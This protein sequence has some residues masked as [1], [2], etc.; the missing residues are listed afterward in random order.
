MC[1]SS[2]WN[3][4]SEHTSGSAIR[5]VRRLCPRFRAA[6]IHTH[7]ESALLFSAVGRDYLNVIETLFFTPGGPDRM[8]LTVTIIDDIRGENDETFTLILNNRPNRPTATVTINDNG[9]WFKPIFY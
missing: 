1:D 5:T 3:S 2:E 9:E 6:M 7:I 8:C 4:Q